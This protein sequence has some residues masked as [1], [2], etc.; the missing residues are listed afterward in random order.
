MNSDYISAEEGYYKDLHVD[1]VNKI[2]FRVYN[3]HLGGEWNSEWWTVTIC[4]RNYPDICLSDVIK[5]FGLA[6]HNDCNKLYDISQTKV[7]HS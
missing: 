5:W 3:I 1:C 4:T 7:K 2:S 6:R